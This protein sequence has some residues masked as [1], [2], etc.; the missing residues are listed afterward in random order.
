MVSVHK[1]I[2]TNTQ[3]KSKLCQSGEALGLMNCGKRAAKNSAVF[4]LR[5]ATTNPSRNSRPGEVRLTGA[6]ASP[7]DLVR[8]VLIPKNM[9]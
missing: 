3:P 2:A 4:G 7:A 6:A 5:K 9:R 8:R 1:A